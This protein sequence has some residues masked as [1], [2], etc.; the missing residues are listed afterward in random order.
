MQ[1]T[2]LETAE[3]DTLFSWK[4]IDP[5]LPRY[6][7]V[8]RLGSIAMPVGAA[9]AL[10]GIFAESPRQFAQSGNI[11]ITRRYRPD[12]PLSITGRGIHMARQTYE[13]KTSEVNTNEGKASDLALVIPLACSVPSSNIP[14]S[15]VVV[16]DP[17]QDDRWCRLMLPSEETAALE[18]ALASHV[19]ELS[20]SVQQFFVRANWPSNASTLNE[21]LAEVQRHRIRTAE[22][23]TSGPSL[24]DW[25]VG[26]VQER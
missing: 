20:R 12:V 23:I 21:M 24:D 22:L 14:C 10:T 5:E 15:I 26:R 11:S 4:L 1:R 19:Y 6:Y 7:A 25:N 18:Q 13:F 16:R 8:P 2:I 3:D 9:G 17:D